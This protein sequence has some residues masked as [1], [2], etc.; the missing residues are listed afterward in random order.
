[1]RCWAVLVRDNVFDR[2]NQ[3]AALCGMLENMSNEVGR[4]CFPVC[5]CD[6]DTL[7]H[8]IG[9]IKKS[10]ADIRHGC[11][12]VWNDDDRALAVWNRFFGDGRCRS[13]LDRLLDECGAIRVFSWQCKEQ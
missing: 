7:E 12:R 4:C 3:S 9:M 1:M 8:A 13:A 2:S 11:S 5:A 6:S 10:A